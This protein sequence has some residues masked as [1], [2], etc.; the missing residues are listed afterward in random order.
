[1]AVM[2]KIRSVF[3]QH[4][5]QRTIAG[6]YFVLRVAIVLLTLMVPFGLWAW[7]EISEGV[8][9]RDSISAYYEVDAL[10]DEF[11]GLLFAAGTAL[12]LYRG[13]TEFENWALNIAGFALFLVALVPVS[14]S[15]FHG[16]AAGA[17]FVAS[18]YVLF[19]RSTD[20][21]T[22]DLVPDAGRRRAYRNLYRLMSALMVVSIVLAFVF[23]I[24]RDSSR[25]VFTLETVGITAFGVYWA[26]KT[27][28]IH[29]SRA[30]QL[31]AARE[32]STAP[33]GVR[34]VFKQ[35]PFST[36]PGETAAAT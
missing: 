26:I 19:F 15:D 10:R 33:Y 16:V 24:A 31:A 30:D 3:G 27:W 1:M 32:L 4:E 12:I 34:E 7:G 22:A 29:E 13:Y 23:E 21:L 18:A 36:S 2:T 35:V 5:L 8:S 28:E 9:L 11:V 6:T 17:F 25:L 20:T 14:K